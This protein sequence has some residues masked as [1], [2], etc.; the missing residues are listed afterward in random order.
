MHELKNYRGVLCND[1]EEWWK[2]WRGIHLS[3][4]NWLKEFDEVWLEHS[5]VSKIYILMR[6][7]WPKYIMFESR[8]YRRVMF[9][10]CKIWDKTDLCFQ[11]WGI[12][13]IFTRSLKSHKIGTLMRSFN[14]K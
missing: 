13:Q 12:W 7:F 14:P 6:W 9:D 1:T 2:I 5:K 11:K 8:K 10:W 4:Q 3:S